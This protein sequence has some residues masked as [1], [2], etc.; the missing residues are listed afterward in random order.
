MAD[1][2]IPFPDQAR[3]AAEQRPDLEDTITFTAGQLRPLTTAHPAMPRQSTG[4]DHIPWTDLVTRNFDGR[5]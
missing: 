2:V 4:F 5:G 3:P 1:N